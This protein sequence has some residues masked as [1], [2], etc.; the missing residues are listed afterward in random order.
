MFDI[1]PGELA[2]CAI[3]LFTI[4]AVVILILVLKKRGDK[5]DGKS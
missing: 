1:G 2:I 5:K 4:V 3:P